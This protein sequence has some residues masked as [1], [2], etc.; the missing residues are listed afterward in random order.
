MSS[1]S[2]RSRVSGRLALTTHQIAVA[3]YDGDR[4]E[5][6]PPG[7]LG[8]PEPRLLLAGET[9]LGSSFVRVHARPSG[10]ARR[11]RRETGRLH[12]ALGPEPLHVRD[13]HGA[14]VAARATRR[15][16][17][18]PGAA[19]EAPS[20]RI[21]PAEAEGLVDDLLPRDAGPASVLPPA[22]HEELWRGRVVRLEPF[23][24]VCRGLEEDRLEG[25]AGLAPLG[26]AL[27]HPAQSNPASWAASA[28]CSG[29]S[30]VSCRSRLI[31]SRVGGW[32]EKSALE[33]SSNFL[34]GLVKYMCCVARL[35]TS[36]TS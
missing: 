3:R 24:E 22:T 26:G 6:Q 32:V 4:S 10:S 30:P 19:R 36:S 14:P 1:L 11:E 21:D 28:P 9:R 12:P 35:A 2:R 34:I 27:P 20:D 33:R 5:N 18:G 7:R 13:V 15:E 16:P 31:R 23:P 8:R 29:G 25:A 17:L